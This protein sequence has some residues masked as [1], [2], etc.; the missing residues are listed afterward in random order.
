MQTRFPPSSRKSRLGNWTI[1]SEAMRQGSCPTGLGC[2]HR[3]RAP[4]SL[5]YYGAVVAGISSRRESPFEPSECFTNSSADV[6]GGRACNFY[7]RADLP[8]LFFDR[9]SLSL[10]L[11]LPFFQ[12]VGVSLETL[13]IV[14]VEG[15][16]VPGENVKRSRFPGVLLKRSDID[17][18]SVGISMPAK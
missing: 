5:H 13:I 4:R 18:R 6:T 12:L 10:S 2:P 11:S 15:K 1:K 14:F 7:Q 16:K 3:T 9:L 17:F 8:P